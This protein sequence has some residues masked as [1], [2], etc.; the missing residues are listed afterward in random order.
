MPALRPAGRVRDGASRSHD[1]GAAQ[2][3]FL[4]RASLPVSALRATLAGGGLGLKKNDHKPEPD[5]PAAL[6]SVEAAKALEAALGTYLAQAYAHLSSRRKPTS[7]RKVRR[8]TALDSNEVVRGWFAECEIFE[9]S[10]GLLSA[11]N[12]VLD[13]CGWVFDENRSRLGTSGLLRT[14]LRRRGAYSQIAAGKSPSIEK[15]AARLLEDARK[16]A[17]R[18]RVIRI[19]AVSLRYP[20]DAE[21]VW[22]AEESFLVGLQF[23]KGRINLRGVKL[24][25]QL[26]RRELEK[27]FECRSNALFFPESVTSADCLDRTPLWMKPKTQPVSDGPW[28][29]QRVYMSKHLA[30]KPPLG[31]RPIPFR[32]I[33]KCD[34]PRSYSY[35]RESGWLPYRL[36]EEEMLRPLLL[37]RWL[38]KR[39]A[40]GEERSI[41]PDFFLE[42]P[43]DP[44]EPPPAVRLT[45][46]AAESHELDREEHEADEPCILSLCL[47]QEQTSEFREFIADVS[48]SLAR[49]R[50]IQKWWFWIDTGLLVLAKAAIAEHHVERFLW[51]IV[52]LESLLGRDENQIEEKAL[53]RLGV[54]CHPWYVNRKLADVFESTYDARSRIVHGE[55]DKPADIEALG[56]DAFALARGAAVRITFL[57]SELSSESK[58]NVRNR[59]AILKAIGSLHAEQERAD[60]ELAQEIGSILRKKPFRWPT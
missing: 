48:Y 7:S 38:D 53:Q 42:W 59:D 31:G 28:P 60:D 13:D 11:W 20:Y 14:W 36:W 3:Q 47:D 55:Y 37:W 5:G 22:K 2:D 16:A 50:R 12:A 30:E 39:R 19:M 23:P 45:T 56:I 10:R 33:D 43:V 18:R 44:F 24:W 25:S 4:A 34:K 26:G 54:L 52:T 40:G 6:P 57:L 29:K 32:S 21:T 1:S 46:G 27:F 41:V 58:H 9:S 8:L 51:S 17:R 35:L 49:I 15:L